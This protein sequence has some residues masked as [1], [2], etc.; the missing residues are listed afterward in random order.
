[1]KYEIGRFHSRGEKTHGV[2]VFD[3]V[4]EIVAVVSELDEETANNVAG[5]TKTIVANESFGG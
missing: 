3:K 1:M 2:I 5:F 4:G